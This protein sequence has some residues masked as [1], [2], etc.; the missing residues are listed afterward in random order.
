MQKNWVLIR[1]LVRGVGHWADFPQML[2]Q[3]LPNDQFE[4]VD[5]PGNGFLYQE[6]SP[7]NI[8]EMVEAVRR[9][10]QFLKQNKKVHICAVSLGG[11]IATA[12]ADRYPQEIEHL[13]LVN[14]SSAK[15]A[16]FYERLRPENYFKMAT[17]LLGYKTR[18]TVNDIEREIV[19]MNLNS[20]ERREVA[21]P[22]WTKESEE[23]PVHLKNF[24][25]QIFAARNYQFPAAT[26]APTTILTAENDHFVNV[27]CSK[28]LAKHWNCPI[29]IHP[30]AGHDLPLDDP[31]WVIE[32]LRTV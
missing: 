4:Y 19:K 32:K 20:A 8:H 13:V 14:S 23:H 16:K 24:F 26:P 28:N 6:D 30:W 1:G 12:W 3:S 29:H 2:Q 22:Y 15:H 21:L 18:F 11:M 17:M 27:A 9:Q 25:R 10:S 5:I 31:Q 7:L